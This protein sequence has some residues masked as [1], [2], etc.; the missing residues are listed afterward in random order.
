MPAGCEFR[1]GEPKLQ[2]SSGWPGLPAA[3]ARYKPRSG[4]V[5]RKRARWPRHQG[6]AAGITTSGASVERVQGASMILFLASIASRAR[7]GSA[8][9][10]RRAHQRVVARRYFR[11]FRPPLQPKVQH[12]RTDRHPARGQPTLALVA[13]CEALIGVGVT[14]ISV[15]RFAAK[16][17]LDILH[18]LSAMARRI[19]LIGVLN[20]DE[21]SD[22]TL[23][24]SLNLTAALVS[25]DILRFHDVAEPVAALGRLA[26]RNS[27]R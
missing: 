9:F 16:S 24:G 25:A 27:R 17:R 21:A 2:T 26:G 7:L 3:G 5:S 14:S 11:R 12:D 4:R 18:G 13:R 8:P 6:Q 10:R 22:L 15:G 1:R 20:V 23:M 19:G